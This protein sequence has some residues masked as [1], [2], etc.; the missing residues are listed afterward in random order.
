[1]VKFAL[2]EKLEDITL[3]DNLSGIT[4]ELLDWAEAYEKVPT[5]VIRAQKKT[6][7]NLPLRSVAE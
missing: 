4:A 3:G 6:P 1:M 2:N 7:D 5:L